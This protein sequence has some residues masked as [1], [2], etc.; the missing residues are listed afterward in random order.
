[1]VAKVFLKSAF[2]CRGVPLRNPRSR[3]HKLNASTISSFGGKINFIGELSQRRRLEVQ[4][5]KRFNPLGFVAFLMA[6]GI[7]TAASH[8]Y[9]DFHGDP[10]DASS[11]PSHH[12]NGAERSRHTTR[13]CDGGA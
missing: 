3:P 5:T 7:D 11:S 9:P 8:L 2:A 1:V 13:T 4:L 6:R 12:G 10:G